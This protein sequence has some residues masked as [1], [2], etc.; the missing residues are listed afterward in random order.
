MVWRG[1]K[2]VMIDV[3]LGKMIWWYGVRGNQSNNSNSI[4]ASQII[5]IVWARVKPTRG[6]HNTRW[7]RNHTGDRDIHDSVV[8]EA[9]REPCVAGHGTM[10]SVLGY[11]NNNS[12]KKKM[13]KKKKMMMKNKKKK[14]K[15]MK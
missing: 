14:K 12:E 11:R 15:V 1:D 13:M 6:V 5:V 10:H 7:C 9:H 3:V 8:H 4:G 2:I